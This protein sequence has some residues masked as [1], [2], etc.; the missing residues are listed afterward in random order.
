MWATLLTLVPVGLVLGLI[1]FGEYGDR[2]VE[3]TRGRIAGTAV[4]AVLLG[5]VAVQF[6]GLFLWMA[7]VLVVV[8]GVTMVAMLR[9]PGRRAALLTDR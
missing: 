2:R 1:A 5:P 3:P 4:A 7:G 9:S 8:C 6:M